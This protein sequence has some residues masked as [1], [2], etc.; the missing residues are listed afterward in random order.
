MAYV[1]PLWY[2]PALSLIHG[3]DPKPFPPHP[4]ILCLLWPIPFHVP[5]LT[6]SLIVLDTFHSVTVSMLRG[7]L[8]FTS[9]AQGSPFQCIAVNSLG[10][11]FLKTT[12]NVQTPRVLIL[13]YL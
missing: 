2:C 6:Q 11:G 3:G 13:I 1:H 7:H 4:P 12:S 9:L 8:Y 10:I 5:F